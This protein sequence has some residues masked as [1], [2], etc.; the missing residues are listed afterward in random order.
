VTRL[1]PSDLR[2]RVE[3]SED[4]RPVEEVVREAF[5]NLYVPGCD[6][7][8]LAHLMRA[9]ADFIPEWSLV[10]EV[11]GRI[12]GSVMSTRSRL[13]AKGAEL[14]TVTIGPVSVLP[15]FQRKGIGRALVT[16]VC[17][18]SRARGFAAMVLLGDPHNYVGYGFRTGK[19]LGI[20]SEDGS[21]PV[22]L[23]ALELVPGALAGKTWTAHFSSVF[24]VPPGLAEFD[25]G[26]PPREKAWQPSQEL[27]SIMVRARIP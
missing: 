24:D 15:E 5:W 19:D 22:G 25:A 21:Y 9:H 14:Q 26:F 12:V 27:F 16:R 7:H 8:Y 23:L 3:T 20:R 18:L 4:H 1:E 2:L 10:A 17:E 11:H 6:E 13:A